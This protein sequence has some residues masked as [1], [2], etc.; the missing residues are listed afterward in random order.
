MIGSAQ[1]TTRPF[2]VPLAVAGA[3]GAAWCDKGR[4]GVLA[5]LSLQ[6][7]ALESTAG[8]SFLRRGR[9]MLFGLVAVFLKK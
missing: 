4:A 6:T 2:A 7:C 3:G 5:A 1:Q 9:C 8:L